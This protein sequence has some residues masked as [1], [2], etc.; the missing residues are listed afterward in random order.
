[1]LTREEITQVTFGQLRQEGLKDRIKSFSINSRSV[2]PGTVF[3][4]IQGQRF[5][6]HDFLEESIAKGAVGVIVTR[7]V[8]V[9][10][11]VF[12]L[13]V[14]DTTRAMGDI[15]QAIR[16][17]HPIP[18]V[19]IT[20]SAGKSSTKELIAAVL[21]KKY[22]VLKNE[23]NENNHIG[24]PL[25]IFKIRPSHQVAVLEIGTNQPGDIARL[26]QII[27]PN[28]VVFTN[29]GDS[30]LEKLKNRAGVFLEKTNVLQFLSSDG[31]I[32]VNGD[33]PRLR[34]ITTMTSSQRILSF[35]IDSDADY[36]AR[37][38][39]YSRGRWRFQC[40]R[41]TVSVPGYA[42][43]TVSNALAAIC[44]GRFFGV[45]WDEICSAVS[46]GAVLPGRLQE[47]KI[48]GVKVMDDTYNANPQSF[49]GAIEALHHVSA[50]RRILVMSDMLELGEKSTLFHQ[51]LGKM[52]VQESL[53]VICGYGTL[54]G[55]AIKAYKDAGGKA[56]AS[57]Y[58]S[59]PRLHAYLKQM[60][61][62]GDAILV[63]GSRG[64]KMDETVKFI[65]T[66]YGG[67]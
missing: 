41:K 63:K 64:M 65:E 40:R 35:G 12:V 5:D 36:Q 21:R 49:Q 22:R 53:D 3:I 15:A 17:R 50:T 16:Q 39:R 58:N 55:H 9:P 61:A 33:D 29:I 46:R 57:F 7:A 30:H 48:A 10:S 54:T 44:C 51:N 67:R 28:V 6:G 14:D 27:C 34:T 26:G 56:A 45:S 18:F 38:A 31:G 24:V 20:G 37:D 19:V 60:I 4:A 47:K 8:T 59:Q 25:T 32:I 66:L 11:G 52:L 1:M 13:Q 62:E 42:R 43:H 23:K 2:K